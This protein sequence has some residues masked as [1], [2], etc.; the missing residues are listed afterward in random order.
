MTPAQKMTVLKTI[1]GAVLV[2]VPATLSFLQS[3]AELEVKASEADA[4]YKALVDSV[5]ELQQTV[6]TQHDDII[7]LQTAIQMLGRLADAP[8]SMRM[9]APA[10]APDFA[11]LPSDLAAAQQAQTQ[12]GM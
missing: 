10:P 4:G 6:T 2:L 11:P 12:M 7:K 1:V 3:R 9:D 8:A 5:K